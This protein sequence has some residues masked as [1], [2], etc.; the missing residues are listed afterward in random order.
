MSL[1]KESLSNAF[2]IVGFFQIIYIKTI[3]YFFAGLT[4]GSTFSGISLEI[5]F[6]LFLIVLG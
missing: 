4:S 3:L 6:F 1:G 2:L 5:V